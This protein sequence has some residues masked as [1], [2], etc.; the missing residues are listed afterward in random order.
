[1]VQ[2]EDSIVKLNSHVTQ[3]VAG[4]KEKEG[5]DFGIAFGTLTSK[6]GADGSSADHPLTLLSSVTQSLLSFSASQGAEAAPLVPWLRQ[7]QIL[8]Q[9][10]CRQWI[11][12]P[13]MLVSELVQYLF[14]GLFLGGMYFQVDL[15]LT[16]GVYNRCSALFFILSVLVFTP[17]FTAVTTF[18]HERSLFYKERGDN[19]YTSSAWLGAKSLVVFPVESFLCLVL[20]AI[21][22]F[23][24][25][26]Q[27]NGSK[28]G[29][30][31]G[32]MTVFQLCAESIGL[33]FA[34]GTK[35]PT[36]A[37]VWL[38]LF[39]II[40]LSL[41]GFLTYS[42]PV[43][44]NWIMEANIMRFALLALVINEFEGLQFQHFDPALNSK[45]L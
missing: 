40:A 20:C 11:R 7:V 19:M 10:S 24:I 17:P 4:E 18:S 41:T 37:I 45:S 9:R 36:Y 44:Y 32:I 33:L 25:G 39:L 43:Y 29:I 1:V 2:S 13:N 38:S 35:S 26:L 14:I 6:G 8:S 31:Y 3:W 15:T 22:Y 42:M 5:S 16:A 12:D 27:Y 23:M 21:T 30:F 28:F 34:V